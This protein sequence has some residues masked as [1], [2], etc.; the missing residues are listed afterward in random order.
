MMPVYYR[1]V[2]I[3]SIAIL[4]YLQGALPDVEEFSSQKITQITIG[5]VLAGLVAF[6]SFIDT[7]TADHKRE[8]VNE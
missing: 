1:G 8:D 3:V 5:T 7:T 2:S 4:T 6:R